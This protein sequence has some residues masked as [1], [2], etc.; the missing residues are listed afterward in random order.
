MRRQLQWI[1]D[2]DFKINRVKAGSENNYHSDYGF[3]LVAT[4]YDHETHSDINIYARPK[5]STY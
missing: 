5:Q 4:V 2:Y 1:G 3:L